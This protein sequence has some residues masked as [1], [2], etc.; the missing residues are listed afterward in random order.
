M[1]RPSSNDQL[2][3]L[4]GIQR[5]LE[6][7]SFVATYKFALLMSLADFAI[8]IAEDESDPV[9]LDVFHL[10]ENFILYYW[11]QA[12][13]YVPSQREDRAYLKMSTGNQPVVFNEIIR[14][15]DLYR[16]SL[17][18]LRR[19][20]DEWYRLKALVADTIAK[21]PLWKLQV[22]GRD[23]IVGILYRQAGP[24]Y[25]GRIIEFVPGALFNLRRHY[26]LVRGLVQAAWLRHVRRMNVAVLGEVDLDE[27]LFGSERSTW[28]GL[29]QILQE[30]Q[31]DTCLYCGGRVGG[32]GDI[33]HF[34]PWSR[35]PLDLGHNFVL[36]HAACNR[37]KSDL[38]ASPLHLE[39][40]HKRNV[41][42]GTDLGRQFS[43]QGILHDYT[44]TKGI[45]TW[46][47][48]QAE[49]M[50]AQ[51]WHSRRE[52]RPIDPSWRGVL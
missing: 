25:Q 3:F 38:L 29:R 43:E 9:E 11:R 16:G 49:S 18:A 48:A 40:W 10:A 42:H 15:H 1:R 52:L 14:L 46:A 47:Y 34:I 51:L 33:D 41:V 4:T 45:T 22:V 20:R 7:G 24:G 28:P 39:S 36:A 8:Q 32:G 6:E 35:Y 21:M 5:I 23:T 31:S 17:P 19:D 30:V 50:G 13:P 44:K 37:S 2:R 27:F 26:E 12:L